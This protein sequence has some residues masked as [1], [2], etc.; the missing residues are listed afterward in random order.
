MHDPNTPLTYSE[1][2]DFI[3]DKDQTYEY[4]DGQAVA[5]GRPSTVHQRLVREL[6]VALTTHLRGQRC[7]VYADIR[8]WVGSRDRVP[9]VAVTFDEYD[10][11]EATD[12]LHSPKLII[13]I[14]SANRGGELDLKLQ[15]Y[16]SRPSIQEYL[17]IDS[18]RR[19]LQRYW[20]SDGRSDFSADPV[21]IAGSLVVSAINYL[22]DIDELYRLVRFRG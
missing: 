22:L 12:V 21:R 17:V 19:W 5:M 8:V 10:Y 11:S 4:V 20:R 7:D 6:V 18:R 14:L 9:D 3:A 2:L 1:F 13:E 15:Q 16:A